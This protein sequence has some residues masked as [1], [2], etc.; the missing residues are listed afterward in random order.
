MKEGNCLNPW[1]PLDLVELGILRNCDLPTQT[2][3]DPTLQL[4]QLYLSDLCIPSMERGR[5][6]D[7]D[8][9]DRRKRG[10]KRDG[11]GREGRMERGRIEEGK[12]EDRWRHG[13]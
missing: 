9:E 3:Q 13:G 11:K 5:E 8:I 4:Q 7:G 6:R 12:E 2:Q 1:H 10:R